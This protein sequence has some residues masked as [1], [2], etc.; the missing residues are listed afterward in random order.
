MIGVAL[1][2]MMAVLGASAKASLDQTLAEDIVADY[3]VAN[4]VGQAFGDDRLRRRG[5]SRGR[6]GGNGSEGPSSRSTGTGTSRS[7]WSPPPSMSASP[8]PDV[9]TGS[10]ETS[11]ADSVAI[12]TEPGVERGAAGR[13]HRDG[14]VRG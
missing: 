13:L 9:V 10:L 12:S 6:R 4:A 14:R 3:V 1:V 7:G 11:D 2:T 8:R 5:A